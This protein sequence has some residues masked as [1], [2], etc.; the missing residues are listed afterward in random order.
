MYMIST[1]STVGRVAITR[2]GVR[3]SRVPQVVLGDGSTIKVMPGR[4]IHVTREVLESNMA[5]LKQYG[6]CV[7]ITPEYSPLEAQV[8]QVETH[9]E[10]PAQVS[11][12]PVA[13]SDTDHIEPVVETPHIDVEVEEL[14][15][16]WTAPLSAL[17]EDVEEAVEPTSGEPKRKGGRRKRG[18]A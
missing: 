15:P 2:T 17:T 5:V 4:S 16:V 14:P 7:R 12:I 18:E 3:G 1:V 8:A 6:E 10:L 11:P 13:V 9:V